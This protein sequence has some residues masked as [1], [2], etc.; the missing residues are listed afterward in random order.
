MADAD[1]R[2]MSL[3]EGLDRTFK[4]Y[5]NHFWLFTGITALPFFLVLLAEV[6]IAAF[7]SIRSH[8]AAAPPISPGALGSVIGGGAVVVILYLLM[9]GAA[10][11]AT[12]FAVS[13]VYLSRPVTIRGS[14]ARVGWKALRVLLVYFLIILVVGAAFFM[15]GMLG[16]IMRSPGTIALGFL[17]LFVPVLILVCRTAVAVPTAMLENAGAVRSLE[18]SLVLTKGHAMQIF[19]IFLLVVTCTYVAVL[20]FQMPIMMLMLVSMGSHRAPGFGLQV[21]QHLGEFVSQVLAGPIGTIAFS[22]MYYNLRVRK[23]AFDIQHL[24][25]T[26]G[27]GTNSTLSS[28]STV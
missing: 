25:T 12:V 14:F 7:A 6:A 11:A 10:H 8:G 13:D 28:P 21:L 9:F 27:T 3:G 17:I 19:V 5:K 18:R 2:P 15:V 16:A 1:L 4:L 22:L 26:I 20:I 23:E 24:M